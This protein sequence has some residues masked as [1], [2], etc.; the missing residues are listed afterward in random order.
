MSFAVILSLR[1]ASREIALFVFIVMG[2]HICAGALHDHSGQL[3]G[4]PKPRPV[5]FSL[6]WAGI[7]PGVTRDQELIKK[8]G[9]GLWLEDVGHAGARA[10]ATT[11][12]AILFIAEL[13]DNIVD[14]ITVASSKSLASE[15]P[16]VETVPI[17]QSLPNQAKFGGVAL[18]DRLNSVYRNLGPPSEI[19]RSAYG[20]ERLTW[21]VSDSGAVDLAAEFGIVIKDAHVD[22]FVLSYGD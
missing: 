20:G 3:P 17:V 12:R 2:S 16:H 5:T 14:S 9:K 19:S 4:S 6:S 1:K 13:H 7:I 11:D 22:A 10:Y 8:Y 18:G 15:I 21:E